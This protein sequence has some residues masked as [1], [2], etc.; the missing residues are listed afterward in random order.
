MVELR[1]PFD[2][3]AP[4]ASTAVGMLHYAKL[5]YMD[6]L[7]SRFPQQSVNLDLSR[8]SDMWD[9]TTVW[10][11]PN[12]RLDL[13]RPLTVEEVKQTLKTMAKGKSPGVDGLTVKFYVANWAAFGPALVDIYNEVLV[14]GKLG[15]GMTHGVISVLFKKGDKAEVR[16]WRPI[17]L[18]NVSYKILAKALARRLSRFLPELVE[19]D[20]GAFVQGRSIFNNIV[21]AIETLEVVQKE[22]LDTAI[23][24]LDLEKAYDKVGWTFVL[25]TLRKM[26][27]SEGFCACII[28]MYTYS[29]SSVMINGHLSARSLRQGCPLAPLVFVLQ[30]EV[31]LNRIRK[32]P[33]I[34]GLRLHTGEE[35]KVKALADDLLAVSENS[36]SSLAALKGVMLEYS[37]LSEASVNWTKSVF[38]LPEQFVLRVEW[39]MRRVE[40]GEEER[41]LGV[42]I[43]L[44]LEMSTQGLLLQQRIAAR[45]KTWEVTWHLSLLGRA[46]VANVALFSILWFVSTV[47][48]LATGIIRAVKRLVGRFIWKPRARLTEGFIS[49]VAMDTLSFPRSKG[50]LGLSDPARRNQAQLRNWVAKL[51]TL[52]SRE[53]WVGTAEQIL[54]SEWSLSRPQDVWDCFFIPSFHKKRLKSRFWEPIRKAWNRLPPDLQS[55]PTTKDE[56]LMQ[57][58][59][60]NPAVTDRNGHPFKAD[61]ST[62][63]FGQAWVKRGIV[64]ISDLWSKLLGCWK[65]PADIKQQLRGLQRVEENWRHLIQGIP[66]EWRSLLGPEGVDPE[67]T[68]YVPDQAAE[69]GMLWKVKVILPSG[70]RRIERWRCESPANVLTLVEQDTIFSW[71]NPSQ[72]RVLEVRGRSASTLSLTWV[73]RLP[74]NQLCVDPL[75]WSWS[76]GAGEEK[77]LRIGEYSVAQGYQQLSRKLKSPA[78][79]AI[80][81][82]QA[83]WEEDLPDAEAEFERLWESLS[84][85]PN[86]KSL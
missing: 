46:L 67:D 79:V 50:G 9:D 86:G 3:H 80:P 43:S 77:A 41:F 20:Q 32:H 82:W 40:P 72:A 74:L 2:R 84:N 28:D 73:G 31:L 36:V 11:Q 55:S 26:G 61:G 59:F 7:T 49:K 5:Y 15:K 6:I 12:A 48:E 83:I 60:E 54:M 47:R 35:C 71:S 68:W 57:L 22:N 21:T 70:F 81:R 75:A 53:H 17:S 63:S 24:L 56:V 52:T 44:Q 39:G 51:A 58:L 42:L 29:T 4:T 85:L 66:Q 10:L 18:L 33:N 78:Q 76:A 1:H 14:G 37:E 16:N 69:P 23:L 30:L 34:R 13:D 27:F 19:K 8:D 38:L 65:P 62:G 45:L 25:T 64:R